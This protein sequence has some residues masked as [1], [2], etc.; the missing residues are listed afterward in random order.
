V[1]YQNGMLTKDQM[2]MRSPCRD[3]IMNMVIRDAGYHLPIEKCT[4]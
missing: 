4:T 2:A 1:K 3:S